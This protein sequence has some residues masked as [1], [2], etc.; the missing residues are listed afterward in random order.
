[1]SETAESQQYCSR[2]LTTF[3]G[4]VEQCPNLGCRRKRPAE[5]WG[6]IYEQGEVFDRT[7]RVHKML[8]VGGAG[9]TYIAREL[10]A[11]GE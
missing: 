6:R 2:C 1:M 8:A 10:D 11:D 7:Y 3:A 5:G 4:D 9:V